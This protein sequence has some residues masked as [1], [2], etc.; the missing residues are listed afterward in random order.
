MLI[1]PVT[2]LQARK[3]LQQILDHNRIRFINYQDTNLVG[4]NGVGFVEHHITKMYDEFDGKWDEHRATE[5]INSLAA[6]NDFGNIS[7]KVDRTN[8]LE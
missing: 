4:K 5:Y 6:E 1:M 8:T 3:K 2:E 7:I